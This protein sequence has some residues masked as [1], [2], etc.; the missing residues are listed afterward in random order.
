MMEPVRAPS[1]RKLTSLLTIA[2][3]V[4]VVEKDR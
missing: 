2:L 3:A 1:H 4:R